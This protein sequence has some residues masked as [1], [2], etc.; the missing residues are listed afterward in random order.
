MRPKPLARNAGSANLLHRKLLRRWVCTMMSQSSIGIS[1]T[2]R[3]RYWPPAPALL[4]R[5]CSP[6][7]CSSAACTTCLAPSGVATS[8][9]Q[10]TALAPH[11]RSAS[12]PGCRAPGPARAQ[13]PAPA[14]RRRSIDVV[15]GQRH[16]FGAQRLRLGPADAP[17][18]ARD[19]RF[20]A[21]YSKVHHLSLGSDRWFHQPL[22]AP[23]PSPW[24][25][26]FVRNANATNSG[27]AI[28]VA[29]AITSPQRRSNEPTIE[30]SPTGSVLLASLPIMIRAKV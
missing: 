18:G 2:L 27:S 8:P 9:A 15:D 29:P 25:K 30:A 3:P 12:A 1:W 7:S 24:M 26:Y 17:R 5:I 16:A 13:P 28:S 4:T 14:Q 22:T 21:G 20:L 10:A 23:A 19:Q 11:W 6:P